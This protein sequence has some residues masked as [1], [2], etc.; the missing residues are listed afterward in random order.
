MGKCGQGEEVRTSLMP[1]L[2]L[3]HYWMR[4]DNTV[5]S[6]F[7]VSAFNL[8]N[9]KGI[10]YS[11]RLENTKQDGFTYNIYLVSPCN[12]STYWYLVY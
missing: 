2:F 6:A 9:P 12:P 11:C 8:N 10:A 7:R 5:G 1:Y 3:I 4:P